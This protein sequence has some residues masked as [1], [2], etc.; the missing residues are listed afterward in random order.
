MLSEPGLQVHVDLLPPQGTRHADRRTLA[1][2]LRGQIHAQLH[3]MV[4]PQGPDEAPAV[5]T[6]LRPIP[7]AAPPHP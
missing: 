7:G 3:A 4:L 5:Q 2:H 1:E 6:G